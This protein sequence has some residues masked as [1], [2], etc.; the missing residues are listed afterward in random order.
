[1]EVDVIFVVGV[2]ES[3][4][5]AE[6]A[7]QALGS[8]GVGEERLNFLSPEVS[9]DQLGGVPATS[10]EPPGIGRVLGAVVG[11]AV[12]MGVGFELGV[13]LGFL[14]VAGAD[15]RTLGLAAA[16]LLGIGG[17]LGG[18]AAGG[19]MEECSS[20]GLPK[21]ELLLYK[22]A[23]RQGSSLVIAGAKSGAEAHVFRV[24]LAHY[25]A[26][27]VDAAREKWWIGLRRAEYKGAKEAS[28]AITYRLPRARVARSV[29]E[30]RGELG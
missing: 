28:A 30:S 9:E 15:P 16:V 11:A 10:T 18:L 22:D 24:L 25:G 2:F 12:G 6:I 23:L 1:M 20:Q 14:L 17:A 5:E 19:A 27:T 7:T 8:S 3:R 4:T 29:S 26:E 13:G 21:D